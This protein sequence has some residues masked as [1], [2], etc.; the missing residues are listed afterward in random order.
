LGLAI[1]ISSDAAEVPGTTNADS[2]TS[3]RLGIADV[4]PP[5][6]PEEQAARFRL[7]QRAGI[8]ILRVDDGGWREVEPAQGVWKL[9]DD[10]ISHLRLAR[11]YGFQLKSSIGALSGPAQWFLKAHPDA[12]MVGWSSKHGAAALRSTEVVSYWYP[13]IRELLESEDQK[14]FQYLKSI[15]LL[16]GVRYL[17]V[18]GGPAGEPIYPAPWTTSD[19]KGEARFWCYD[20]HAR[21]SFIATERRHYG[22]IKAANRV[23]GTTYP[24]WE[25]VD[26]P[27]PGQR[28]GAMWQD[29]L[30]WYRDT[31]REFFTWQVTHYERLRQVYWSEPARPRLL[32][33]V[34]GQHLT[35]G[36][37]SEAIRT[38][39]GGGSIRVMTDSEFLL[40]TAA[41][42]GATAQYTGLPNM[43]ELEYLR[44]YVRQ[45][46][47]S[48]EF[49]GENVGGVGEPR[50][51]GFEVL[52]NGLY[53]QEYIGSDLFESNRTTPTAKF[54]DLSDEYSWLSA[55]WNGRTM[56]TLSTAGTILVPQ[57]CMNADATGHH[58]LCMAENGT[59]IL[60]DDRHATW[61][62]RL[63]ED[64]ASRCLTQGD[65]VTIFQG[66]GNLVTYS[67]QKPIWASGTA[68]IG[69][70]LSLGSTEP[71]VAIKDATGRVV[72]TTR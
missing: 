66:D 64:A 14:V 3:L 10:R 7:Y 2:A 59:L 71:Y 62:S 55:T 37:W 31:K 36:N 39:V 26:V 11:S 21:D 50:D 56:F 27:L 23:W 24:N 69:K 44:S 57:G 40:D 53:G 65:C 5:G 25:S 49:W 67:G 45:R 35:A 72:W 9:S 38:G 29:V 19:P 1:G 51:I 42:A 47:Y 41:R 12:Q 18:P 52:S 15:G 58:R 43:A 70:T 61:S 68:S 54:Q 6:S 30:I 63:T 4:W 22:S 28:P 60:Y 46:G 16:D 48:L 13:G 34:P 20:V 33:L 8:G 32:I 17:V